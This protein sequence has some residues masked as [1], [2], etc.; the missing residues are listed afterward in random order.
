MEN[1]IEVLHEEAY[2]RIKFKE[3]E[4]YTVRLFVKEGGFILKGNNICKISPG[5][6]SCKAKIMKSIYS[7]RVV[8]ATTEEI[9]IEKCLHSTCFGS[10]CAECGEKIK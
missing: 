6:A 4:N 8:K 10:L 9:V 3:N 5:D 7:G 1:L 2:T